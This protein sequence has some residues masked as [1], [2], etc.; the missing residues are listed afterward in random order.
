MPHAKFG[1]NPLEQ[2]T[3]RRLVCLVTNSISSKT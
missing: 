1:P 3:W 2:S